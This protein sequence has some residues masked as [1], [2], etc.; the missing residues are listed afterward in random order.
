MVCVCVERCLCVCEMAVSVFPLFFKVLLHAGA[1][2][3]TRDGAG[4]SPALLAAAAGHVDALRVLLRPVPRQRQYRVIA[5]G[6][7]AYR[8]SQDF[9][10]RV[11]F[12]SP[13]VAAE[14][15]PRPPGGF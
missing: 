15:T 6:G 7:I 9:D 10:A 3:E 8:S 4:D 13:S 14:V 11:R 5:N 1:H 12:A 2:F